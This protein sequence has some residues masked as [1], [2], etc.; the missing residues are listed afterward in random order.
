MFCSINRQ[1]LSFLFNL[2][3]SFVFDFLI[4]QHLDFAV[5]ES[6]P[7]AAYEVSGGEFPTLV[8]GLLAHDLVEVAAQVAGLHGLAR[9]FI[10]KIDVNFSEGFRFHCR[11]FQIINGGSISRFRDVRGRGALR[12][13]DEKHAQQPRCP[14]E[15]LFC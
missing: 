1:P 8:C 2:L 9:L 6:A 5:F 13:R 12:M 15:C 4:S 11:Q 3:G 10:E 14:V 7:H